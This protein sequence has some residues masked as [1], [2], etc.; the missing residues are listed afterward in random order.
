MVH[1]DIIEVKPSKVLKKREWLRLALCYSCDGATCRSF[2]DLELATRL[3]PEEKT[4]NPLLGKYGLGL[5]SV[6]MR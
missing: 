1:G 2:L 3:D 4:Y 6:L 5:W